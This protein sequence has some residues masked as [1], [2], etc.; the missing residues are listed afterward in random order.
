MSRLTNITTEG[1]KAYLNFLASQ[2]EDKGSRITTFPVKLTIDG[3]LNHYVPVA[4]KYGMDMSA[5]VT[6]SGL[7]PG[8]HRI[9]L[10]DLSGMINYGKKQ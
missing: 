6:L 7:T 8:R 10:G 4:A 3:K 1:E 9:Q 5:R 2:R